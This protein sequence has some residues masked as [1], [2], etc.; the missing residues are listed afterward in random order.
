MHPVQPQEFPFSICWGFPSFL[1]SRSVPP[2]FSCP[3]FCQV[4]P[5]SIVSRLFTTYL[6]G[7]TVR[8]CLRLFISPNSAPSNTLLLSSFSYYIPDTVCY[9]WDN[10]D[11]NW[12]KGLPLLGSNPS[13]AINRNPGCTNHFVS[14]TVNCQEIQGEGLLCGTITSW[15]SWGWASVLTFYFASESPECI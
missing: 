13:L 10:L 9:F 12:K 5:N 2:A 11:W 14:A 1:S 7:P 3:L 4:P 6:Q 15:R 8:N